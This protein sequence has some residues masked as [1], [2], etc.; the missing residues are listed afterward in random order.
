M[1]YAART[2]L[3]PIP[4][5][6]HAPAHRK[7]RRC[8]IPA[9]LVPL[10]FAAGLTSVAQP[11]L[12]AASPQPVISAQSAIVV[13]PRNGKILF[14]KQADVPRPPASTQKLLTALIVAES[15]Q[16]DQVVRIAES[17]TRVEPTK[18][19]ISAGETYTRRELLRAMLVKSCNDVAVALARDN[20]GSV[21]AFANRM[22]RKA[23][24]LGMSRSHFVNPN[25]LPAQGQVSTA[26]DLARLALA[27]YYNPVIRSAVATRSLVF[28]FSDGRSKT[29]TN[30]NKVLGR[31]A[32][33]NGMK[34]G[35]TRASGFCLI[36]SASNQRREVVAVVLGSSKA[37]IWT[38]SQALLEWALNR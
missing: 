35:Y 19:Y 36:S 9:A 3:T 31:F 33:C 27:A 25:G 16:L 37:T 2:M 7:S 15:G 17:D 10:V 20:A 26:R 13:D 18:L 28:R 29:L 14:T 34:T 30:T 5:G 24:Q 4:Q 22:N 21:S 1:R 23:A 32:Y 12:E 38:D 6:P 8:R 11:I